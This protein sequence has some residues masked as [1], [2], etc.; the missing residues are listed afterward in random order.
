M[1]G[2]SG[3][4]WIEI[5]TGILLIVLGI[6][7][8]AEPSV[9]MTGFVILCGIAALVMGIADIILYIRVERH[10]GFG[11]TVSLVTGILSVMT[12]VMLLVYPDS[13]A[14]V[15]SLLFPIWFIAHCISRLSH[16][17]MVRYFS[18]SAMYYISLVLNI[19]GLILGIMMVFHPIIA[20]FSIGYIVGVYLIL[21]G[22]D[23]IIIG[24]SSVGS[25]F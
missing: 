8:C 25:R 5:I 15:L 10:T 3:F 20:L 23:S 19:I 9:V 4:G 24:A 18:G 1:R 22:I 6:M 16:L 11:P 21:L 17:G 13:G 2:R 14:L 7:I 12:A